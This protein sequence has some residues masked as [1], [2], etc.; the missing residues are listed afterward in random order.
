M[1]LLRFVGIV[2]ANRGYSRIDAIRKQYARF[3]KILSCYFCKLGCALGTCDKMLVMWHN[4]VVMRTDTNNAK[5]AL[6]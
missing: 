6:T 3:G 1:I 4:V 5:G 2:A